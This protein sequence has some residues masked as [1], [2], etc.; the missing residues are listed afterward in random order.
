MYWKYIMVFVLAIGVA[1]CNGDDD[2][3]VIPEPEEPT[4]SITA[5]DQD[6][7]QN[8]I[9]VESVTV[10]QDS[11]LV[12]VN[13]EDEDTEEFITEPVWIEEGTAT[14][15]ELVIND[16]ADL[17]M[18]DDGDEISLQLYSDHGTLGQ[19]DD[20]DEI[21]TDETGAS[22]TETIIIYFED[23]EFAD[24]DTN[25]DGF[26]D[27]DE[28]PNTFENDFATWDADADGSLSSEEFYATTF[29][30]TDADDDDLIDEGEWDMGY[31]AMYGNYLDDDFA[32]YD[33][34]ADGYV[35][36]AEWNTVY[37]DSEWYEI[38]DADDDDLVTE[39]EWNQGLY[40]DW[41]TDDDN[42]INEA[43]YNV[44]SPYTITW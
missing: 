35:N 17:E 1:G 9:I 23:P 18:D 31:A 14:D 7:I 24:F 6:V 21:I 11:W 12:A 8:T 36:L 15:V 27:E 44:Y 42:L 40:A 2:V 4:G 30:N 32:T 16:D 3:D 13:S 26:I 22:E 28:F 33:T 20:E 38:Y 25:A 34:D 19:W 5:S 10:G 43:E 41:D 39:D 29:A 37:A